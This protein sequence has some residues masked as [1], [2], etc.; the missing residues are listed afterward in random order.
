MFR[1]E[2]TVRSS[3]R[4][5]GD[6]SNADPPVSGNGAHSARAPRSSYLVPLVI[7]TDYNYSAWMRSLEYHLAD[8]KVSDVLNSEPGGEA[9]RRGFKI[10]M[11][12]LD[13]LQNAHLAENESSTFK[14]LLAIHDYFHGKD[15][16]YTLK[17]QSEMHNVRKEKKET[18][19]Q[20][21]AR[22]KNLAKCLENCKRSL[23]PSE[24][25]GFAI[26]GLPEFSNE[27]RL[28]MTVNCITSGID[29]LVG[30]INE[31]E[32][33][34]VALENQ[35]GVF[36]GMTGSD[37]GTGSRAGGGAGYAEG[38]IAG[39]AASAQQGAGRGQA[40]RGQGPQNPGQGQ[41]VVNQRV[42]EFE[43]RAGLQAKQCWLCHQFG[44]IKQ[45]C[46]LRV[47]APRQSQGP[48]YPAAQPAHFFATQ[49]SPAMMPQGQWGGYQGPPAMGGGQAMQPPAGGGPSS[50]PP[51]AA[52]LYGPGEDGNRRFIA[53][54]GATHHICGDLKLLYN[55]VPYADP[56]Q[57]STAVQ[58][59]SGKI[60]GQGDIAFLD[61]DL[62]VF[63][64]K[65]V[66]FVPGANLNLLS[67]SALVQ[68]G[69]SF[70]TNDAGEFVSLEDHEEVFVCNVQKDSGLYF[71]KLSAIDAVNVDELAGATPFAMASGQAEEDEVDLWHR[72]F[73]HIGLGNLRRLMAGEMLKGCKIPLGLFNKKRARCECCVVGKQTR[74]TFGPSDSTTSRPLELIHSD[75]TQMQ[76][77]DI[78]GHKYLL[79]I[80]DDFSRYTEVVPLKTKGEASKEIAE[81]ILKW[82]NQRGVTVQKV[83]TDNGGEYVNRELQGFFARKGIVHQLTAPYCPES[84]GVAERF[85]R[86]LKEKIRCMN[87]DARL[88]EEFWGETAATAVFL[89]NLSP[90]AKRTATPWEL[91][92]GMMPDVRDLKIFGCKV[93]VKLE[94]F[95]ARSIGPQSVPG[96]FLGYQPNC[97]GYRVL[98]DGVVR[99][100]RSVVFL[101]EKRGYDVAEASGSR[102]EG[103]NAPVIPHEEG[104]VEPWVQR[105]VTPAQPVSLN[106]DIP[107]ETRPVNDLESS[108][109]IDTASGSGAGN[110]AQEDQEVSGQGEATSDVPSEPSL[111]VG[112]EGSGATSLEGVSSGE[113][114][115]H[116]YNTRGR[117]FPPGHYAQAIFSEDVQT[118]SLDLVTPNNYADVLKSP[119]RIHWEAAMKEEMDSLDSRGTLLYV[120]RPLS[121]KVL[122]VRWVF[123]LKR[124]EFGQPIRFKARFVVKGFM[125]VEGIDYDET[126]APVCRQETRRVLISLAAQKGLPLHQIDVKTAFLHGELEEEVYV[127][128]P[129]GFKSGPK[130]CKLQKALYGLKQAPRAWHTKLVEV[131]TALGFKA[132]SSDPGLFIHETEGGQHV[133]LLTYVDDMLLVSSD[134]KA[135]EEVKRQLKSVFDIHD[136]GEATQFLG[137]KVTRDWQQGTIKLSNP[138]KIEEVLESFGLTDRKPSAIPMH[139]SFVMSEREQVEEGLVGDV[140]EPGN[141]YLELIGS[142]M[143]LANTVRPDIAFAVGVLARYRASPTTAHFEAAKQVLV[144]LGSTKDMGVVFGGASSSGLHGFVDA[145]YAGCLDTRR[146]TTG[147][148]FLLNGGAVSWCSRKQQSVASS[149]VES[150]YMAFHAA[151]K[152]AVW[153]ALLVKELGEGNKP[154]LI[155]CDNQGCI[156]NVKNPIA[157]RYVKHID[158]AYHSVR[159]LASLRRIVPLYVPTQDNVADAFTKPLQRVKFRKFRREMGLR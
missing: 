113:A 40:G 59:S 127:E 109:P 139:D 21:V 74:A 31:Y 61:A 66:K 64:V 98:V 136:L 150:E 88:P 73:G 81:V 140:L 48:P 142:L 102:E 135:V 45:N 9:E 121:A 22:V 68:Q 114:R 159:E 3:G 154:V 28:T 107:V 99:V 20:Y 47:G 17:M 18:A 80:V 44:H 151:S 146:S 138:S 92:T 23:V 117:V 94:K 157:S 57:L 71:L 91:F 111:I 60:L 58:G 119:Q 56:V 112:R 152:E 148:V 2:D 7:L 97:K 128:Q 115:S 125:Q 53:D 85:N 72:R 147:Y 49:G 106:S 14:G 153:L 51:M 35:K 39:M 29:T 129:P 83:R 145:D 11:D 108:T 32:R 90:V 76:D 46:P 101:E 118:S 38:Y 42:Q 158:V 27:I 41:G 24:I 62:E 54:T 86:T 65:G 133:Y 19:R 4:M 63:W 130:V 96:T 79:V 89:R 34:S 69:W 144:Y 123:T 137:M 95:Q 36:G 104:C 15:A 110:S 50:Q 43:G 1:E 105:V 26:K 8:V 124:D 103:K 55:F 132:A 75:V 82:E 93:Y 10:L 33:M 126:Y 149:T 70:S 156:A 77:E 141:R 120:D 84:N 78:Y 30:M 12:S 37:V 87:E 116:P 6:G 52:H 131:L 143:Y 100:Y 16:E 13:P 122:P 67:V 5:G 25:I 155:L 134:I